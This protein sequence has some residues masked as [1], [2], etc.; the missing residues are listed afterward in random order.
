MASRAL[1]GRLSAR[2]P[3]T[4][5]TYVTVR[6]SALRSFPR[7]K[8][9]LANAST[10][11]AKAEPETTVNDGDVADILFSPRQSAPST[12][13]VAQTAPAAPLSA[14]AP[15]AN[16]QAGDV[17]GA[18][19]DWS[20]SYHGLSE[21]PFPK[22][23][24]EVLQAPTDPLDIEVKPGSQLPPS[25]ISSGTHCLRRDRWSHILT[26]DQVPPSAEQSLRTWR[27]GPRA[28]KRDARRSQERQSRICV[29]VSWKVRNSSCYVELS[30]NLSLDSLPL[31]GA[32]KSTL[33]P[34]A[35]QLPPKHARA[36]PS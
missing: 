11:A 3:V 23:V 9:P 22:E 28:E 19:T 15:E 33:T 2:I 21:E 30:L 29:G 7:T 13:S 8:L 16:G 18:P 10:T 24:A 1:F 27:L 6:P 20:K 14:F 12:S 17:E 34:T 35:S 4:A 36:M 25:L 26:R 32:S 5:R 31:H